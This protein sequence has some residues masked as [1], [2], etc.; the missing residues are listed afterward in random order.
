MKKKNVRP[1]LSLWTATATMAIGLLIGGVSRP[2]DALTMT[3]GNT[4]LGKVDSYTENGMKV[5]STFFAD[6]H[7]HI[8]II[9]RNTDGNPDLWNHDGCC[10]EV[11]EFTFGGAPFDLVSFD[12]VKMSNGAVGTFTSSSNATLSVT[13]SGSPH[14]PFTFSLPG[15]GWSELTSFLWHQSLGNMAID[16]LVFTASRQSTSPT[17][18]P[19]TL[20]LLGTGLAG[21][22][23]YGW[24][25]RTQ[26]RS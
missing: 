12:V 22:L 1:A 4:I 5:E 10:G 7:D 9:D 21:L 23:A 3:F 13:K 15:A 14:T 25:R 2:A 8:H 19:G 20:M 11:Y 16:N 24:R 6:D 26:V 18:E 17:P